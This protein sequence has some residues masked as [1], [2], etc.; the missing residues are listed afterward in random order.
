MTIGVWLP[1]TILKGGII[2]MAKTK[3]EIGTAVVGS[4][5]LILA[6]I[7]AA[8]LVTAAVR[9]VQNL[10]SNSSQKEEIENTL[11]PVLMFDPA[12]FDSLDTA[13]PIMLL[14]SSI[15][16]A[17][18]SDTSGKYTI[19]L[20]QSLNVAETDVDAA[21]IRL[22]GPDVK[23]NHQTFGELDLSYYYNESGHAYYIPLYTQVG[24][25]VPRVE[26]IQ[27]GEND[28]YTLTVGY[29]APGNGVTV[30]LD[31]TANEPDKYMMYDVKYNRERKYYYITA[32]RNMERQEGMEFYNTNVSSQPDA[33]GE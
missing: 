27:K 22:F 13:D 10:W 29:V 1:L 28:I 17:V 30:S 24:V 8:F 5:I 6:A 26:N 9:A 4:I 14:Q 15:W 2:F 33:Q 12:P 32:I 3:K 11:L 16:S 18:L 21:A 19:E 20:G 31:T 7:G 23:L 25:Y